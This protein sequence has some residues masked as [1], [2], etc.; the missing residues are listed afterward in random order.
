MHSSSRSK[1]AIDRVL[2]VKYPDVPILETENLPADD[3]WG[4]TKSFAIEQDSVDAME[5]DAQQQLAIE[6]ND[7]D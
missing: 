5:S 4:L 7:F 2:E 6:S 1:R 3:D